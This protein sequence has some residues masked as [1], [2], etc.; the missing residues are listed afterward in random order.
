[1]QA[2]FATL[3][4]QFGPRLTGSPAHRQAAEWARDRMRE[5]GLSDPTLEPWQFGRGW[6]LDRIVVEMVEPRYMPLIGYADA[7]SPPTKGEIVATPIA[8]D[9]RLRVLEGGG[10]RGRFGGSRAITGNGRAIRS[11]PRAQRLQG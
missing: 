3:T 10:L 8:L 9:G 2:L 7:W 4:D 6:V 11:G 5:F 1:M